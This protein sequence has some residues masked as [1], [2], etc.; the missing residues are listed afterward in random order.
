MVSVLQKFDGAIVI[1]MRMTDDDVFDICRIETQFLHPVH[2]FVLCGVAEQGV[3]QDD[4]GGS[5]HC[6]GAVRLCGQHVEVVKDLPTFG[7]PVL[8]R[9]GDPTSAGTAASGAGTPGPSA[10]RAGPPPGGFAAGSGKMAAGQA[11]WAA[12][13]LFEFSKAVAAA[14]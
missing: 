12:P 5:L 3:E 7:I 9:R 13:L 14:L 10:P 11:R 8:A 6:P 2:D 1:A 4:A